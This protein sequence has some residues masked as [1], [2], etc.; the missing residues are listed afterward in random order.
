MSVCYHQFDDEEK[1]F[2]N[3]I[4]KLLRKIIFDPGII[5]TLG[6]NRYLRKWATLLLSFSFTS[7]IIT[8]S[9][10]CVIDSSRMASGIIYL[11]TALKN[12]Y[13]CVIRSKILFYDYM[14]ITNKIVIIKSRGKNFKW[15]FFHNYIGFGWSLYWLLILLIFKLVNME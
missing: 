6:I 10:L 13:F 3:N 4:Q 8:L 11:R 5:K 1:N 2:Q 14:N 12:Y 9:Y 15:P 7:F